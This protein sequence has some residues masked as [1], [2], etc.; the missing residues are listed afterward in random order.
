ML[1]V[2]VL[3]LLDVVIRRDRGILVVLHVVLF[4]LV[5]QRLEPDLER[6]DL[7]LVLE[8]HLFDLVLA[9]HL[10]KLHL[11]LVGDL[12]FANLGLL[13]REQLVLLLEVGPGDEDLVRPGAFFGLD[14][15]ALFIG[16]LVDHQATVLSHREEM[17]VVGRDAE[18]SDHA[19]VRRLRVALPGHRQ[20]VLEGPNRARRSGSDKEPS[21]C[22]HDDL[23]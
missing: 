8:L 6:L 5:E 15:A 2:E 1:V 21:G 23:G 13:L 4:L 19:T 9:A 18:L 3:D 14:A 11:V 7:L 22:R 10:L 17:L 20:R 12:E 16:E